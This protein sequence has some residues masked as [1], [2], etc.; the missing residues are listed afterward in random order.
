MG[1]ARNS[2]IVVVFEGRGTVWMKREESRR[3]SFV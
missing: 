1:V 3:L 2:R